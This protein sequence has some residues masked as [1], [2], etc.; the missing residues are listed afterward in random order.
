MLVYVSLAARLK[1]FDVNL[2]P[3]HYTPEVTTHL[4]AQADL[5]K[6]NHHELAEV[7]GWSGDEAS[8]ARLLA[9]RFGLQAVCVDVRGQW[10]ALLHR[11]AALPRS[12]ACR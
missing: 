8:N 9:K 3:P 4:L 10:C 6:L 11:R 1:V 12:P 7:T 5:V 2:R